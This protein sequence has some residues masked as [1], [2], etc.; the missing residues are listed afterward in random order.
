MA[1]RAAELC[2]K[3]QDPKALSNEGPRGEACSDALVE[4]EHPVRFVEREHSLNLLAYWG[5]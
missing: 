2:G 3:P 4:M 1:L 5:S